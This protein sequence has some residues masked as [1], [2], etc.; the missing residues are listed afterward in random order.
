MT[1]SSSTGG[2]RHRVVVIGG[3]FGG[4]FAA[5]ALRRDDVDVT[6]IDKA[7]HHLFQPLLYQVSTGILSEGDIAP[8]LRI[9]LKN[10]KNAKLVLGEVEKIDLERR[11]VISSYLGCETAVL[12]DN[13]IVSAG[14]Q[15]SYF[16]NDHF[17]EH[18]PGMKTIDDA[19]ELRGRILEAFELAE[20]TTDDVVRQRLMT[21]VVVGA[22]PTGVE[23]AG[24]IAELSRKT[25]AGAYRQMDP[26]DARVVIVD[27]A[28]TALPAFGPKLG[29]A[30]AHA[31]Q[32]I[33][34]EVLLC[35]KVIAVDENGLTLREEDGATRTI[36]SHCKVWSAGVAASPLGRQ[37][38]D[39]TGA[40]LDRAGRVAVQEDLIPGHPNVFV[41][42]DMMQL[43]G[44][45][46][47]AQVAMQTGRYAARQI[48][49]EIAASGRG[50]AAPTRKP[51]RYRD[52]GSMAT[53]ARFKAV[54]KIGRFE[55]VGVKAWFLW[56]AVHI[57]YVMGF[58]NRIS[59]FHSWLWAF[60]SS[61]RSH[62]T[63]T[64]QQVSARFAIDGQGRR[65]ENSAAHMIADRREAS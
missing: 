59:T 31:L 43:D 15:Q 26:R 19:L 2:Q 37:L 13:L 18:A 62:L 34:V 16:G 35:H 6:I 10:Q 32:S 7:S 22:G 11:V 28:P 64:R 38:A 61:T 17:A 51:F 27:A 5:K 42:G 29:S 8:P 25:L 3:G 12:F 20:Q 56:L 49:N 1:I 41:I 50:V 24:Q 54:A 57:I 47:V 65:L 60:A 58:K 33:G 30:A 21:F 52:K 44:L 45:P 40:T 48:K 55:F 53:I 36:S 63:I 46:G 39:Q 9:L 4:L 14:A 23:V